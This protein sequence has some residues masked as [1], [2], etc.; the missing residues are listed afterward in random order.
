MSEPAV[1]RDA[2]P[3]VDK[4][5]LLADLKIDRSS[6]PPKQSRSRWVSGGIVAI[7]IAGALAVAYRWSESSERAQPVTPAVPATAPAPTVPAAA[8]A[9]VLDATGY[10][11]AR[12][13][14]TVSAKVTGKV[15]ELFLEE[16]MRVEAGQ[17]LARLDDSI[18]RA[19]LAL[20]QAQADAARAGLEETAVQIR[21]AQLDLDRIASLAGRN[22]MSKA[23]LDRAQ[24][25]LEALRARLERARS[26]AIVAE[27]SAAVQRLLLSDMEIRA[28]FAGVVVAKAA[29][30]GEMISPNS[31]GGGYTRTGICTIVDMTSLEV[32]VDVNEAYINRVAARQPVSVALNAYPDEPIRAEVI[33]IIPTADRNKATVRVRIALLEANAHVLP[34][35]GV[36]VA[37][38]N[39]AAEASRH[40]ARSN[41]CRRSRVRVHRHRLRFAQHQLTVAYRNA[42]TRIVIELDLPG[43]VAD[44]VVDAISDRTL[45]DVEHRVA[46]LLGG[47]D[48]VVLL[49]LALH[50]VA[51]D[52][53]RRRADHLRT[54][55]AAVTAD[56]IARAN[57]QRRRR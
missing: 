37:F 14:S 10:V 18:P 22:L 43:G 24:L 7:F 56:R 16:G 44:L 23:D 35:M 50:F 48:G 17:L 6:A 54:R 11:V 12:R 9:S 28:P 5:E 13:Y 42:R 8:D 4:R 26:D 25:S 57:R 32:E 49:H 38:L 1:V 41:Y 19:A 53:A 39:D 40:V 47:G 2:A 34:D 21:Q 3:R 29:Q 36:K 45:A 31:A 30:P 51:R 33:A 46:A 20:A 15:A 55:V 27:R 52:A